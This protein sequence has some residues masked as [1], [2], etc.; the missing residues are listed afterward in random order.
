M[1]VELDGANQKVI[2]DADSDTYLQGSTDDTLDIYIAGAKDFTFTANTLTAQSG[3]TVAAQAL[4]ATTIGAT[5]VVSISDGTAGA[6]ALT[7]TGDTN[8]GLFFSAAD[9]LAFSAGGT[10]QFTMADGVV[11]PVTDDDVD[12]GTSSL[13]FKDGYFDGT[14]HCDTLNL[15]GTAHTSIAADF[16]HIKTVTASDSSSVDFVHGTSDVVFDATYTSYQ[17][18]INDLVPASDAHV[19]LRVMQSGSA[20]TSSD[21]GF[22]TQGGGSDVSAGNGNSNADNQAE[23]KLTGQAVYDVYASGN[24]FGIINCSKPTTTGHKKFFWHLCFASDA[25]GNK[26]QFGAG[27]FNANTSAING[28]SFYMDSGNIASGN[29]SLYGRKTA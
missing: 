1:A 11:A 10:S 29:F 28:L 12:L 17:I 2:I 20:V 21:Y 15:A 5:G 19:H 7:N 25:D 27:Q 23:F 24:Y 9:T 22:F 18:V 16:V 14:L 4:T 8:C 3:S 13:E 6:P 26:G